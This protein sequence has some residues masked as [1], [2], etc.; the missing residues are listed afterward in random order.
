MVCA[1]AARM[2][3]AWS[4]SSARLCTCSRSAA[5]SACSRSMTRACRPRCCAVPARA[6]AGARARRSSAE[7][8]VPACSSATDA[9]PASGTT[10]ARAVEIDDAGEPVGAHGESG[11]R[12]TGQHRAGADDGQH[13]R[14]EHRRG[15]EEQQRGGDRA[16]QRPPPRGGRVAPVQ[17]GGGHASDVGAPRRRQQGCRPRPH[18]LGRG[19]APAGR[20]ALR[21]AGRTRRGAVRSGRVGDP[22][23][24]GAATTGPAPTPWTAGP[25]P[26]RPGQRTAPR[27]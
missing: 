22:G 14:G 18:P 17:H 16:T 10:T 25:G 4:S 21:P 1:R 3:E 9:V 12:D 7:D 24:A 27:S 26:A 8:C 11:R 5:C 23:G 13:A 2:R 15:E 20:T 19:R 6:L